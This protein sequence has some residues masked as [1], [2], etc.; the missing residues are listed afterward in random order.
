MA[1]EAP[2]QR[3][4]LPTCVGDSKGVSVGLVTRVSLLLLIVAVTIVGTGISERGER[5][6]E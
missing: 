1:T 4:Y 5:R 3:S 6:E 2:A